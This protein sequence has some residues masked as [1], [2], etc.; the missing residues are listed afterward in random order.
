MSYDIV[1][2]TMAL[3]VLNVAVIA[4]L[5]DFFTER[6]T[7]NIEGLSEH[8]LKQR[9]Y[10]RYQCLLREEDLFVLHM[11]IGCSNLFDPETNKRCR[12]WQFCGVDTIHHLLVKYGCDWSAQAESGGLKLNGRNTKAEGWIRTLRNTLIHAQDY[13]VMPYCHHLSVWL[14]APQNDKEQAHYD[15]LSTHLLDL[16]VTWREKA[17]FDDEGFEVSLS[18]RSAFEMWLFQQLVTR[19]QGKCWI[20]GSAPPYHAVKKHAI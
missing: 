9:L 2:E 13:K 20:N 6:L 1:Y 12:D 18:P 4:Q 8:Q 11:L 7:V 14:R 3:K 5:R 16:D 19:Y 10:D 17:R 15:T